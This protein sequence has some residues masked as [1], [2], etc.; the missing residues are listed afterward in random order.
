MKFLRTL[1]V[2]TAA[3]AVSACSQIKGDPAREAQADRMLAMAIAGDVD[4]ALA[5]MS[6]ELDRAT[7][8]AQFAQMRTMLPK[9]APPAGKTIGFTKSAGTEGEWYGLVRQYDFPAQVLVTETRMARYPDGRWLVQNF[10]F[11]RASVAAVQANGFTL[12]GKTP[13]HYAVLTAMIVVASGILVTVGFAL[14]RRRWLW[15]IFALFGFVTLQFNWAT[16][17]W[18]VQPLNFLLFGAGFLRST[19]PFA[20]WIFSVALPV[21]AVLFWALGKNSPKPPKT[22]KKGKG[23]PELAVTEAEVAPSALAGTPSSIL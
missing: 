14:Y 9:T 1:A 8:K 12:S 3:L 10:N 19:S 21:G 22:P 2:L 23:K 11:N 13:L 4:A 5:G 18:M 6:P 7:G 17:G 20:P 16:G 15:A